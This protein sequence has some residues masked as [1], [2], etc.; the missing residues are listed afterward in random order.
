MNKTVLD[1]WVGL[2]VIAG[3]GA[4]LF[5]ALKVGSMST[6][7]SSDSYEVIADFQNIGGLKPRAPV[8]SAGVVVGRVADIR[9]DNEKYEAAVTLRLDKRYAFPKDTSAAIMTSGLLGEQ[10]VGLEAG[11]DSQKL[12]DKDRILITQDAVVLENLIG[13]FLYGKAQEGAPK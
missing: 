12:K 11:G 3:I 6:V 8:K 2:F 4:L 7:N 10:Y 5:L 9:F 13:Q 1:F